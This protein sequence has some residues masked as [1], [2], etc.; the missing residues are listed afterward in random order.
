MTEIQHLGQSRYVDSDTRKNAWQQL[1]V[2][3]DPRFTA[4]EA[5]DAAH[6]SGWD[7]RKVPL[8]T[9]PLVEGT[10]DDPKLWPPM[11]IRGQF[12]SIRTHP[13]THEPQVLGVVGNIW[14]P[15]QNEEHAELLDTLVDQSGAH[16]ETA[17]ANEDGT[18][19]F[20]A[21]KLPDTMLVGDDDP[22]ETYITGFNSHT[23]KS[24][25][26]LVVAPVRVKC[27]NMQSLALARARSTFAIRHTRNAQQAMQVAREALKLTWKYVAAFEE[28]AQRMIEE[29]LTK[30]QFLDIVDTIWVPDTA[31]PEAAQRNARDRRD[32]LFQLFTESPTNENIRGTRWAGLQ[33][34]SEWTDHFA[35]IRGKRGDE[36]VEARARRAITNSTSTWVKH[37][38]YDLLAE[39]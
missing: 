37:R 14:H 10:A 25:F 34:F 4:R 33:A 11:N 6:L 24:S 39:V 28:E 19:A 17:G 9:I 16:Y 5:L 21:M 36:L 2:D 26:R 13:E 38:A 20:M 15:I 30:D 29:T 18:E 31:A 12:A 1:G 22:V 35:T 32:T 7:V 23:G 8:Q 27:A 3:L